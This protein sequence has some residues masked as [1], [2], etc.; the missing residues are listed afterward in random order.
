MPLT[1]SYLRMQEEQPSELILGSANKRWLVLFGILAASI[2]WMFFGVSIFSS[3]TGRKVGIG[4]ILFGLLTL[5]FMLFFFPIQSAVSINKGTQIV[6]ASR[7]YWLGI[8]VLGRVREK[9]WMLYKIT[10]INIVAT[11]KNRNIEVCIDG[12]KALILA[13]SPESK[14]DVHRFYTVVQSWIMNLPVDTPETISV[15]NKIFME[16]ELSKTLKKA[17]RILFYFFAYSFLSGI[18]ALFFELS[19]ASPF[20]VYSILI[21]TTG[22]VYLVLGYGV[23]QK[24][25][26]S[27]WLAMLVVGVELVFIGLGISLVSGAWILA[28][29]L[30]LLFA[31]VTLATLWIAIQSIRFAENNPKSGM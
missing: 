1:L 18:A 15:V 11:G 24:A 9:T 21:L 2:P 13:L 22:I 25:E 3:D 28:L 16:K 7:Q 23:R 10:D 14:N 19:H 6:R 29:V 30:T 4:F 8:G 27:L 17:E 12:K 31:F 26:L 5:F 20:P